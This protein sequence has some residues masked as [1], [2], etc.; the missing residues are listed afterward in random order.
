M[1]KTIGKH[2]TLEDFLS[3]GSKKDDL[4]NE[5]E[6]EGYSLNIE[7]QIAS[8]GLS[9]EQSSPFEYLVSHNSKIPHAPKQVPIGTNSKLLVKTVMID[10]LLTQV[11]SIIPKEGG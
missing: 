1:E 9:Q 4:R 10:G 8:A 3:E 2:S 7:A 5:I 11:N 6:S